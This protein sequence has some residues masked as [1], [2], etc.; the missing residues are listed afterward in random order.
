MKENKTEPAVKAIE[1]ESRKIYQSCQ[2]PSYTCWVSFFPGENGQWYLTCEEVTRPEKPLPQCT[3][4]QWYKKGLP[5]NYDKSQYLMEIVMLESKDNMKTWDMVGQTSA[6]FQHSS[7]CFGQAR[8]KDGRFLRFTWACNSLDESVK[9][10]EILYESSDNGKTWK[11]MPPIHDAHFKSNAHRL[12][13]LKD[14]TLVLCIPL[15]IPWGDPERPERHCVNLNALG[16]MQM[17]MF[18]SFDQ[19]RTWNGPLQIYSGHEVSETDFVELPSGD[20]LFINNS[21]FS[22]PGRQFVYRDGNRFIPGPLERAKGLTKNGEPNMVP[23]TVCITDENL[24]VGAHRSGKYHFSDDL[25]RS[26]QVLQGIPDISERLGRSEIYQPWIHCLPDGQIACAGHFGADDPVSGENRVDSFISVQFFRLKVLRKTKDTKILV[27]RDYNSAQ[28]RW[29]NKYT[30]T[31]LCDDKPLPEKEIEF[32][33]VERWK[34]GY[35]AF[36]KDTL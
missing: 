18:F 4:K 3:P 7:G 22:H 17:T 20:L 25:G 16:E 24:L 28:R 33:Y 11:K 31:L 12:R 8:T 15:S 29:P 34:P 27:K 1:F 2:R 6:Q 21:I 13:T 26:W 35:E 19:G 23:E 36:R 30:L 32:W 5:A 9:G 14:R 10:N